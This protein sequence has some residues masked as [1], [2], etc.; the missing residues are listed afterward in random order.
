M[1][2]V[3]AVRY[4]LLPLVGTVLV[5]AAVQFGVIWLD[6]LYQFILMLQYTAHP[7]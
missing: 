3:M 4:V 6:P 7:P 5:K 2:G 1:A